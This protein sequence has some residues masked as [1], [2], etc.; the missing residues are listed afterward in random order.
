MILH[1]YLPWI[2]YSDIHFT[3]TSMT[4]LLDSHLAALLGPRAASDGPLL[5]FF[6]G[7]SG[8]FHQLNRQ[9]IHSVRAL[10]EKGYYTDNDSVDFEGTHA[11]D[12]DITA[13]WPRRQREVIYWITLLGG[14]KARVVQARFTD[15][16]GH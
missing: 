15:Y 3:H 6:G 12:G 13:E 5:G 16:G 4:S 7:R 14:R 9:Q 2:Q 11:R 1:L 8:K 10:Q